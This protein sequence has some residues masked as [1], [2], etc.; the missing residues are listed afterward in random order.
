M[1]TFAALLLVLGPGSTAVQ[2]RATGLRCDLA[3]SIDTAFLDRWDHTNLPNLSIVGSGHVVR[4][5]RFGVYPVF[6][7]YAVDE[8][9]RVHITLDLRIARPDGKT[10]F[11]EYGVEAIDQPGGDGTG[12]LLPRDPRFVIFDPEDPAGTYGVHLDAHDLVSGKSVSADGTLR[13]V[14]YEEGKGFES[15]ADLQRWIGRFL[16]D[17]QPE[18]AIPALRSFALG[19][20]S[21]ELPSGRGSLRE[22]FEANPW[23]FPILFEGFAEEDAATR[24]LALWLLARSTCEA[25]ALVKDLGKEDRAV[26]ERV[27]AEHDPLAD[28]IE[29]RDDV[30]ELW[31]M[32]VLR[33]GFA[34]LLR[35]CLALAPEETDVVA[36]LTIHDDSSGLDVPLARV[37]QRSVTKI[38]AD[39]IAW[40]P[41]AR[42]YFDVLHRDEALPG[43]VSQAIV[44]LLAAPQE[45][46][47]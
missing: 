43:G 9:G 20:W 36:D 10:Y 26:W 4:G 22:L 38:L 32:Y 46:G 35:L 12:L 30:N 24:E 13:L 27:S 19:G 31:G 42:G 39:G 29:G 15:S 34:P 40:D 28:P 5:Q 11:E 47:K 33:R 7:G 41:I 2:D 18:R 1:Q 14:E 21:T 3:L 44:D 45:S 23:L 25:E 16:A 37:V 6:S 8:H 17:P